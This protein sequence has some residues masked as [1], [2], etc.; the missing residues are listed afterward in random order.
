MKDKSLFCS[1][2]FALFHYFVKKCSFFWIYLL[3]KEQCYSKIRLNLC[4]KCVNDSI[5]GKTKYKRKEI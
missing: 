5:D 1:F 2:F 3:T 4:L